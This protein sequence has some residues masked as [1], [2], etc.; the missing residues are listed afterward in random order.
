MDETKSGFAWGGVAFIVIFFLLIFGLFGFGKGRDGY[1]DGYGVKPYGG[2][3][4]DGCGCG[5]SHCQIDKDVIKGTCDVIKDNHDIYEKQQNEKLAALAM[6]VQT[7]KTEKYI[8][9][10]TDKTMCAIGGVA[11]Q[12]E[13]L[14][15]EC[16]KRPPEFGF[17]SVP[18]MRPVNDC[19]FDCRR[20]RCERD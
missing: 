16:L 8:D 10:Q 14:D 1:G 7:L 18:C 5:P 12:V 4:Y 9:C 11:H 3:G 15:C 19:D 6:E 2:Y 20:G 17:A 13:R